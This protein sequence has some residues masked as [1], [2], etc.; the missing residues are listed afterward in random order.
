METMEDI[1]LSFVDFDKSSR[2]KFVQNLPEIV[3]L[4]SVS[5]NISTD[6]ANYES[7][8]EAE[9]EVSAIPLVMLHL[10][11]CILNSTAIIEY[12]QTYM[13]TQDYPIE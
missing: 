6:D 5:T 11:G 3:N 2:H 1:D 8:E 4:Y 12:K 10:S 9:E 7:S 13:N